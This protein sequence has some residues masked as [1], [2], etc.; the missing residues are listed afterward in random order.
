[1]APDRRSLLIGGAAMLLLSAPALAEDSAAETVAREA[2]LA[3]ADGKRLLLVFEASWCVWCIQMDAMLD[4]PTAAEIL[5][6]HFRIVH[7]RA[8]ERDDA[9][10][11]KQ[12]P[13]ADDVYLQYSGGGAGMPF[14]A[15]LDAEAQ[16]VTTSVSAAVN[17]T[18]F[19][20]P[21]TDEE[22]DGFDAMLKIAAPDMSAED[23]AALRAVCVKVMDA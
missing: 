7:L 15:V 22:L 17:G 6:R 1:M 14:T 5:D 4:D 10:L 19:G 12:L 11:A 9:E 13:G 3:A 20:F 16:P 2:A 18:N 23:R 21:V 8:Q